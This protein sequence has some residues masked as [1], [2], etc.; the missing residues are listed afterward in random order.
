MSI[1]DHPLLNSKK[2]QSNLPT[3]ATVARTTSDLDSLVTEI[4]EKYNVPAFAITAELLTDPAETIVSQAVAALGPIEVLVNNAG[5][6]RMVAFQNETSLKYWWTVHELNVKVPMSFILAVL[7]SFVARG[8]G[9]L[10]TIGSTAAFAS[11]YPIIA[12][13]ALLRSRSIV[14]WRFLIVSSDLKE[15]SLSLFT[16]ELLRQDSW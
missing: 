8:S 1:A 12:P 2:T 15:F 16:Q 14:Q 9:T 13:I 11:D 6:T 5:V 4:K 7:P 3:V 10:I